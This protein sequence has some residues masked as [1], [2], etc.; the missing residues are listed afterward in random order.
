MTLLIPTPPGP[1]VLFAYPERSAKQECSV[2][3]ARGMATGSWKNAHRRGHRRCPDC[4]R[5]LLVKLDGS[6]R[7][8]TRCPRRPA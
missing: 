8:H 1:P 3:G 6:A 2:C 4:R 7:V 5:W